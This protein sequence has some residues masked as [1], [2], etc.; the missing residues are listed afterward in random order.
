M[1]EALLV[2]IPEAHVVDGA[3]LELYQRTN[4][5]TLQKASFAP[6]A[7]VAASGMKTF[8]HKFQLEGGYA[9]IDHNY[10]VI[11]AS[12]ALN[13][14]TW[15]PNGD[16]FSIGNRLFARGSYKVAPGLVLFGF[17]THSID[18]DFYNKN[19]EGINY[20]MTVDFKD[21]LNR[22]LHLGI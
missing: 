8:A 15:A 18:T 14:L 2:H 5:I 6:A 10:A 3:R 1:R 22:T 11:E 9:S 12:R 20:G 17:Y 13:A 7:G 19:C 4:S 16:S 21:I